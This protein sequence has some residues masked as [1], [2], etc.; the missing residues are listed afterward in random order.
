MD[1]GLLG[2]T[3]TMLAHVF[4]VIISVPEHLQDED[5]AMHVHTCH[6]QIMLLY[7]YQGEKLHVIVL[8]SWCKIHCQ[9]FILVLLFIYLGRVLLT[10]SSRPTMKWIPFRVMRRHPLSFQAVLFAFCCFHTLL[11]QCVKETY[12]LMKKWKVLI[13]LFLSSQDKYSLE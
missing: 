4:I 13:N 9:N 5:K 10:H 3:I 12:S 1:T 8:F 2:K 7:S 6:I 11:Q